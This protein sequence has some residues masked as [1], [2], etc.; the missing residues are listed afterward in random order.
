MSEQHLYIK[1]LFHILTFVQYDEENE[2][3]CKKNNSSIHERKW[4]FQ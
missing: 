4:S 2:V 3:I 1:S